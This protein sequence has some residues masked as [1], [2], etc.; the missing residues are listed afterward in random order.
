[1]AKGDLD[2][3]H[4]YYTP[5]GFSEDNDEGRILNKIHC[6]ICDV[7]L[8]V[9]FFQTLDDYNMPKG[10]YETTFWHR[11]SPDDPSVTITLEYHF[12]DKQ[13]EKWS[14]ESD[15]RQQKNRQSRKE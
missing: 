8:T 1:M 3:A 4:F 12:R 7:V 5:T 9:P 11:N 2:N 13:S 14:L 10:G 15:Q 6:P